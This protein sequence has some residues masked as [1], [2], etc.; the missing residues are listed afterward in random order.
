MN[1]W[2]KALTSPF[3]ASIVNDNCRKI[4]C[5]LNAGTFLFPN[6]SDVPEELKTRCLL[7]ETVAFSNCAGA[8]VVTCN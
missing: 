3:I 1:A 7:R 6:F 2:F 5:L 4:L 8:G